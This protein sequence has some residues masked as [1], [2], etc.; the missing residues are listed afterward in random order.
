MPQGYPIIG[1]Q[2]FDT[3]VLLNTRT[4][5]VPVQEERP[6]PRYSML[7]TANGAPTFT[8]TRLTESRPPATIAEPVPIQ[9]AGATQLE[10]TIASLN[11]YRTASEAPN[12][13]RDA[14]RFLEA[15]P[16][17][18][19]AP[20]AAQSESGV[21]T[22]FWHVDNFYADAEFRGNG[23]FSVFTRSRANGKT[24]DGGL[25]DEPVENAGGAWLAIHLAPMLPSRSRIAAA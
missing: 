19:P 21:I 3:E 25:D 8:Q 13:A 9:V 14:L 11:Q 20:K 15:L 24:L 5:S 10:R 22:L 1:F 12:A 18:L 4:R 17:H 6:A 2:Q 16:G 7:G 23:K